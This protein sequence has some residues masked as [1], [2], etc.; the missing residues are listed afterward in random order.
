V[1]KVTVIIPY[2]ELLGRAEEALRSHA[3]P[4]VEHEIIHAYGTA[5]ENLR[6]GGSDI[7]LAR[8][9]TRQALARH[10]AEATV[11][12]LGVTAYDIIRAVQECLKR[13]AAR[14]IAV[15]AA[16]AV[17]HNVE[18]LQEI[19]NADL[20]FFR[21]RNEREIFAAL[22]EAKREGFASV[23]GGLT[24][25]TLARESGW[26]AVHI[27]TSDETL[28]QSIKEAMNVASVMQN[29]RAKAEIS[30]SILNNAKEAI[31]YFD[32]TGRLSLFNPRARD[33]LGPP[34]GGSF[35]GRPAEELVSD[36]EMLE[37]IRTRREGR[38]LIKTVNQATL[39]CDFVPVRVAEQAIG[40]ICTFQ[41]ARE[42]QAAESR[43][44]RELHKKGLVAKY[45]FADLVH[46]SAVMSESIAIAG[47]Y[48]E[49]GA[50]VLLVGET[51]TGK[52]LFAQSIHNS[53][54]R[55]ERPFVAVNCGA[56]PANLLE[57]ELFG[58]VEGSFSGAA[59][60]GRTGLFELAHG[61]TL[62]LDEI[63]EIPLNLQAALLRAVQEGEIRRIGDD[64][65]IPV[66]VRII[67]ASNRDLR[68]NAADGR[69]RPDLLY[70]LDVLSLTIP[71][72]RE[73][74]EDIGLVAEHYLRHFCRKYGTKV[75]KWSL[76]A[77]EA[78]NGH[79][80]PGNVR[81][82]KN[83]CE[84]VAVLGARDGTI[85]REQVTQMLA[86][87][88]RRSGRVSAPVRA[89]PEKGEPAGPEDTLRLAEFL[90]IGKS[91][92][93]N[94]LGISR[95]TLWRRTGRGGKGPGTDKKVSG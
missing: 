71:P 23:V 86:A 34:P 80:W 18:V 46:A 2:P 47:K 41:R 29:E 43:I 38:G 83:V 26:P 53:S 45:T 68:E 81:E 62:F 31:L 52:E 61:G 89:E 58:Y 63:G 60:G 7:V 65:M 3:L 42:I 57:S 67:A 73:R 91:D 79:D 35:A 14:R 75:P 77:L 33:L 82:L 5:V 1:V 9:L 94:L 11:L 59:R 28:R 8:G 90:G 40:I 85:L 17:L 51:G 66:D 39:V 56:F 48:G 64:R 25:S 21:V 27:R 16:D 13:H 78:L 24:A 37:L 4:G 54:P 70:R 87:A 36:P 15:I 30:R 88:A 72:L 19:V 76:E 55:R 32:R 95:T 50:N 93:A 84:R 92:L 49:A 22:E 74:R 44:R 10:C 69:F 6:F 12:E 20:K